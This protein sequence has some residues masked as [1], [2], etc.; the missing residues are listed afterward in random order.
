MSAPH[1][2]P[3]HGEIQRHKEAC[4]KIIEEKLSVDIDIIRLVYFGLPRSGKT[5]TMRR[6]MGDML[7]IL[8]AMK[9]KEEPSTGVADVKQIF[10]RN[11]YSEVGTIISS[12]WSRAD[13]QE[14]AAML[15][16]FF[17]QVAEH[18]AAKNPSSQGKP[19]STGKATA[20]ISPT[21]DF[22]TSNPSL[23][24]ASNPLSSN[25]ETSR[26]KGA[27]IDEMFS[28]FEEAIKTNSL[29]KVK[30][31]LEDTTLLIN[32]DTGGHAEFLE[33]HAALVMGPSLYLLFSRLTDKLESLF[34][35]YYTNEE[36][37]SS[38]KEDST[39]TME[40]VFFQALSS[41]AC[42]S[43]SS[44]DVSDTV[45]GAPAENCKQ[46]KYCTSHSESKAL[47][48]GT[49]LDKI[50]QRKL[51]KKD[52]LLQKKVTCTSF[53][54]KGII[55]RA[56]ED[57]L[58]L[59]VNNY[60][61]DQE[62]IEEVRNIL[63]R[64][65]KNRFKKI[66][67]PAA[68]LMLSLYIRRKDLR[69]MTLDECARLAAKLGID[70]QEEL[71]EALW[72][73]H[74][75]VG[76]ILYYPK[77]DVLKD[78]VICNVQ[79]IFDSVTKLI[80]NTFTL[81]KVTPT[82][83]D[84]FREKAQFTMED[85]ENS[86]SSGTDATIPLDKLVKL[87]EYLNILTRFTPTNVRSGEVTYF[88][89]S[90]LRSARADDLKVRTSR[91][92]PAPLMLRYNCGYVPFG[93]FSYMITNIVSKQT[94]WRLIED[95]IWKNKVQFHVGSDYDKVT[96]ISRPLYIEVVVSRSSNPQTPTKVLCAHIRQVVLSTLKIEKNFTRDFKF[97]FECPA[98]SGR[99]H[100]CVLASETARQMECLKNPKKIRPI[101]LKDSRCMVWFEEV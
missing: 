11:I 96:L 97:A 57:Q 55:E 14:E 47:F 37:K 94:K 5:S 81:D 101:P 36:G 43:G 67:I 26:D 2:D 68:W 16:Q 42:F 23:S 66:R 33:M 89:P 87:L 90:I 46:T 98:H 51:K 84:E 76:L 7:N 64:I 80:K 20:Q 49:H 99:D 22:S 1:T 39:L 59:A 19:P 12:K 56:S 41:I 77:L 45:S 91:K 25:K 31:L 30:Y 86:A 100:L 62:E 3:L 6:L 78:T 61:G 21:T 54:T 92:D 40:E 8:I 4:I 9:E 65:I 10:V 58:M 52:E 29:D 27:D 79:V 70:P 71:Q 93:V 32:T 83:V 34:K 82:R 13:L 44:P 85:I 60:S 72:F 18:S 95:K 17:Y 74:H 75:C 48:V 53:Y 63:D 38:E 88:M 15:T 35:V 73:L 24:S 50:N 28:A 69:V